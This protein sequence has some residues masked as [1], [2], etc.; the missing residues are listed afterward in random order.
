MVVRADFPRWIEFRPRQSASELDDR[1]FARR[2]GN[3]GQFLQARRVV[4]SRLAKNV[5]RQRCSKT[6]LFGIQLLV[7]ALCIRTRTKQVTCVRQLPTANRM[8]KNCL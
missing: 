2:I 3:R 8:W 4:Y 1:V 6:F 7:Q 5:E